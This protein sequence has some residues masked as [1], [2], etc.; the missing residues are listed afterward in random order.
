MSE[1]KKA[2]ELTGAE[3]KLFKVSSHFHESEYLEDQARL[4]AEMKEEFNELME[5]GWKRVVVES[6]LSVY[7]DYLVKLRRKSTKICDHDTLAHCNNNVNML[8][9]LIHALHVSYSD[10][11]DI[12][13]KD[14]FICLLDFYDY[15]QLV[16]C[17]FT[18]YS[19]KLIK[20]RKKS[21]NIFDE[22]TVK[23]CLCS[24]NCITSLRNALINKYIDLNDEL[25]F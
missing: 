2:S 6:S 1:V 7:R 19:H 18:F 14:S 5:Y 17:S 4:E 13:E 25:P 8:N 11:K 16:L 10:K 9:Q 24:I 12:C 3:E 23:H 20:L 15:R 21:I 22:C